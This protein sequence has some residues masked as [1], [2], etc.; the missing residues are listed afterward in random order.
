M[1]IFCHQ[2]I[3]AILVSSLPISD[4]RIAGRF[5]RHDK[6]G[7]RLR[8]F[9]GRK[10][11]DETPHR[12][13]WV[14]PFNDEAAGDRLSKALP[15][16]DASLMMGSGTYWS[17]TNS[18]KVPSSRSAIFTLS[19]RRTSAFQDSPGKQAFAKT[20]S[21]PVP[22]WHSVVGSSGINSGKFPSTVRCPFSGPRLHP[23]VNEPLAAT[24]LASPGCLKP[25][26]CAIRPRKQPRCGCCRPAWTTE[27]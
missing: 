20:I 9:I 15:G 21:S 25:P 26:A 12:R 1:R 19:A 6:G 13:I 5:S 14:G 4:A 16:T 22:I 24:A 11:F 10:S 7:C 27:Q 17:S 3:I 18:G 23:F 8:S 2:T